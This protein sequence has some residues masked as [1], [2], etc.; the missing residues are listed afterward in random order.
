MQTK[1][2]GGSSD[3]EMSE[4]SKEF[5]RIEFFP[6]VFPGLCASTVSELLTFSEQFLWR[7]LKRTTFFYC[8]KIILFH[9]VNMKVLFS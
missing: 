6:W 8:Q 7:V 3:F 5:A 4:K 2:L 9:M 1:Q